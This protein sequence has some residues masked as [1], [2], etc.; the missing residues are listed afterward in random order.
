METF[1]QAVVVGAGLGFGMCAA[2]GLSFGLAWLF[3]DAMR[4]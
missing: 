4:K 2:G 1:G 3:W